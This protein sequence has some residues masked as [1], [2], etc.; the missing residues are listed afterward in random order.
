MLLWARYLI[1]MR[2][3]YLMK[4][5]ITGSSLCSLFTKIR[6]TMFNATSACLESSD[7]LAEIDAEI[8]T[9]EQRLHYL[10][11]HRNTLIPIAH[12]PSEILTKIFTDAIT[13]CLLPTNI[14]KSQLLRITWVSRRWRTVALGCANLWT[15][16]YG[17]NIDW[18]NESIR[19]SGQA[20]LQ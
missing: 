2:N 19:R 8:A 12:L 7:I 17:N 11:S 15:H 4:S 6:S 13:I 14:D 16:I 10:R 3:V 9:L 5:V 20:P 1:E 18:L